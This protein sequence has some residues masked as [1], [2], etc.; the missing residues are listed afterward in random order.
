MR[1]ETAKERVFLTE[2]ETAVLQRA[3]EILSNMSEMAEDSGLI[4]LLDEMTGCFDAF[5]EETDD[6]EIFPTAVTAPK[7][8]KINIELR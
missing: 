8:I 6:F 4:N 5:W 3:N 7:V 2:E 1:I